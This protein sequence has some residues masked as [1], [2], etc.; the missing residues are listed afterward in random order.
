MITESGEHYFWGAGS[1]GWRLVR[2]AELS[3]VRERIP[4]GLGEVSHHH[5]HSRQVF[6]VLA[7]RLRVTLGSSVVEVGPQQTLEIPP[8]VQHEVRNPYQADAIFL[9]ASA[10]SS[11]G[12][13]V[14][15]A[16]IRR[17]EPSD[18]AAI[19]T[20]LS[21]AFA[22]HRAAYTEAAFADTV[23]NAAAL[24]LRHAQMTVL[25]AQTPDEI[26]A[27]TL[28]YSAQ[29][30]QGHLR[31]MA[32]R[33]SWIGTGIAQLLLAAVEAEL[34]SLGVATVTLEVTTPLTRARRFYE[35]HGFRPT[36]RTRDFFGMA[37]TELSKSLKDVAL[38][39]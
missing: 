2:S 24:E 32:V 21:E 4:A 17:A 7:G 36:G 23:L 29:G 33:H 38:I 15:I 25:T 37:L 28:A 39:A 27:G 19:L 16:R 35:R 13:R 31:G 5:L 14:D 1:E 3:L 20:C 9:L 6:I 34:R 26:I 11:E 8:L 30:E 10:P 12:D 18:S 22:P